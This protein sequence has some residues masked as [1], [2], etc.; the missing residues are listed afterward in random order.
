[1]SDYLDRVEAQL[2]QRAGELYGTVTDGAERG[3]ALRPLQPIDLGAEEF[4]RADAFV[5]FDGGLGRR[6]IESFSGFCAA[7]AGTLLVALLMSLG[8]NPAAPDFTVARGKGGSVTLRASGPSSLAGLNRKLASLRIPI[9]AV[10]VRPKC[11]ALARPVG[12]DHHALSAR[13]LELARMPQLGRRLRHSGRAMMSVTVASPLR[14]GETL[15]VAATRSSITPLAR[16]IV[17]S[18]PSC[19]R[20]AAPGTR[21]L[22]APS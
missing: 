17:G 13:R 11:S 15:V 7:T 3:D 12:R 22:T 8:A 9:R 19:V 4:S 14:P 10:R 20:G 1:V 5:E 18:V 16:L 2:V 21:L 6:R